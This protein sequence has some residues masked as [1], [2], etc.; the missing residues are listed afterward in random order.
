MPVVKED[1]RKLATVE[2]IKDILPIDGADAIEQAKVRGWTVV[3]KKGE[4]QVNDK[5][6]Y[7]EVDTALPLHDVRF[8]FLAH[9]GVKR[10]KDEEYHILKTVRLRG[11]YSQGLIQPYHMW[12]EEISANFNTEDIKAGL[13]VT[14]ALGLGKWEEPIP[15]G[16]G[17]IAGS[18]LTTYARKTDS[19][20]A[21]NLNDEWDAIKNT[22]WDV[23][24]KIDG[25]SATVVRDY[26]GH[27]RVMGR[28]WEI[29]EGNNSYWNIVNKYSDIF[30]LLEPGD[31]VQLEIAGVGINGNKLKL[32]NIE[33]FIFDF[34]RNKVM[35]P[36]NEWHEKF[37][38]HAVPMLELNLPET[39]TELVDMVD[40]MKSIINPN[41]LAEG[42]VFH[43]K[44]GEILRE[45]G[46]RNTFKVISKKFLNKHDK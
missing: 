22:K 20:R 35:Q 37:L 19:E 12:E 33:P 3:V 6:V 32:D 15:L 27:L 23:T 46:N 30:E 36:R 14:H 29:K 5:V 38:E 9:R 1:V 18:F 10:V 13:N 39:A 26:D 31:A 11:V 42:V 45:V 8:D 43:S 21:E 4:F 34:S 7:F 44:S 25:M 41:V 16:N 40:G 2:F 17:D 28:N 24:E